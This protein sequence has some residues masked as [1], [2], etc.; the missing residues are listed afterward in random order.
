MAN[1]AQDRM[2]STMEAMAMGTAH[3]VKEGEHSTG[4]EKFWEDAGIKEE[5]LQ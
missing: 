5:D 2:F 3:Y 4:T 1:Y